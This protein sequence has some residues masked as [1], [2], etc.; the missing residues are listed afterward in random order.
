M[1]EEIPCCG[2]CPDYAI[3]NNP[4]VCCSYLYFCK[5]KQIGSHVATHTHDNGCIFHPRARE[6]LN[7]DAEI[8][9]EEQGKEVGS[10]IKDAIAELETRQRNIEAA[11]SPS[12]KADLFNEE[13]RFNMKII[14]LLRGDER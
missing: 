12:F 7:R 3:K 14:A 13:Y 5:G 6:Y 11:C 1:S 10:R 8:R 4:N 2:N 9:A